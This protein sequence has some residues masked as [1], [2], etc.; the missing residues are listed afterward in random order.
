ML[1]PVVD[2][3]TYYGHSATNVTFHRKA[4]V[5]SELPFRIDEQRINYALE[6]T[7]QKAN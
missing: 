6:R 1:T 3:L 4:S 7:T 5:L 2:R